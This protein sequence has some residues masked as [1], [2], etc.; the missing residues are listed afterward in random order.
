MPLMPPGEYVVV[1]DA[2]QFASMSRTGLVLRAG[3]VVTV[4]FALPTTSFSE[5]VQ[6]TADQSAVEV[7]RT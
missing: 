3:Q 1:V 6:V 5:S 4:E 2:T 7:G